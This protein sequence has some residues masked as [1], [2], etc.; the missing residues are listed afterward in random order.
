MLRL[1]TGLRETSLVGVTV[2]V[3]VRGNSEG[4]GVDSVE[5]KKGEV[6]RC[7]TTPTE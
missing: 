7:G 2:G 3:V 1:Y 4:V 6:E 5:L